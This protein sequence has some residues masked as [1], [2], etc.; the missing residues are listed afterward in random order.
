MMIS[1]DP[2]G[3]VAGAFR[4]L[5]MFLFSPT[6]T[7]KCPVFPESLL[8]GTPVK[9]VKNNL[10][11]LEAFCWQSFHKQL[12]LRHKMNKHGGVNVSVTSGGVHEFSLSA[13]I[14]VS[15]ETKRPSGVF[16]LMM[17]LQFHV[18]TL[19]SAGGKKNYSTISKQFIS[20]NIKC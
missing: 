13:L 19:T 2:A 11:L 7:V 14:T 6:E 1:S 17:E 3:E 12:L 16:D 4:L 15:T 8:M 10:K 5:G 9:Q 20:K 18:A